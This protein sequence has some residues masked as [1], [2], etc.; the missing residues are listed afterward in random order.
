MNQQATKLKET[1]RTQ[2][3]KCNVDKKCGGCQLLS[4]AYEQQ[5]AMKQTQITKLLKAYG[6]VAPIKGMQQPIYYRNK[7]HA[8]LA[9]TKNGQVISG[10]YKEGT[11]EVIPVT[12]CY[13]ENQKADA[14]I[15]TI[16][17][18][19]PSFKLQVY[20]EDTR[21]GLV[22]HILIRTGHQSGQIMVVLVV[23]S[24]MFPSKQNFIKALRR[25]HPEITTIVLN[26]ND[27]KTSMVLGD[28]EK[29]I[30]GKGYIEDQLC[31]CTFRI[32]PKSFYQVNPVQTKVLYEKAISL[33]RLTGK[34]NVIDAYCGTGT[35]GII[36]AKYAKQVIGVELNSDAI[37]DAKLNAKYNKRDNIKF[38]N[39]DASK[40]MVDL[41][42]E[43]TTP[44]DVVFMDP[45][46]AGSTKQFM[47]S[48]IK[49]GPKRVVYISCNPETLARDLKYLCGGGYKVKEICPVDMFPHTTHVECC[50]LLIRLSNRKAEA[51]VKIDVHV[52]N[53]YKIKEI[54]ER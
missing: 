35:I 26:L 17:S 28:K 12:N 38:Y 41:A 46:R 13:L 6:Y 30:Y 9:R 49:L 20:N 52:E 2:S 27:K 16:C 22:R 8:A 24:F 34:E 54:G 33:A 25:L 7:V 32:S 42:H 31:D 29:V 4:M 10:I 23:S 5:L 11:H 1:Q 21:T 45:P 40:F 50:V 14:I 48:V 53:Y 18:L 3:L 37:K 47:D 44:I 39:E 36:A 19:L 15:Q 51:M 43:N